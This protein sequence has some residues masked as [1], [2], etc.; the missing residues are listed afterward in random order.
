MPFILDGI[1]AVLKLAR[2][3]KAPGGDWLTLARRPGNHWSQVEKS[4]LGA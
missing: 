3:G 4:V 1:A 2:T